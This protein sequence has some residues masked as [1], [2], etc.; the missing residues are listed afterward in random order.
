MA[1]A[2]TDFFQAQDQALGRS[3]RLVVY[4][5]LAVVSMVVA[6]YLA[7]IFA[8]EMSGVHMV[9][10]GWIH[11]DV[12]GGIALGMGILI[13]GGTAVRTLQLR[14]GGTA[15]AELM[16]GRRVDPET[17]DPAER[18]YFNIVEE[19]SIASGTPVPAVYVMDRESGINAFAAGY[20]T[21]DAAVAVTRGALEA[22]NRE[23]LQGVVAH[24]FSHILNGDMRLNIRLVGLLF[25]IFLLTVVGRGILRGATF[26]MGRHRGGGGQ[27]RGGG[28]A[29]QVAIIGI[30]LVVL[31]FLGVFFGRLIQA[32]ISRQ[33]E[34]LAD[35]AAV[36]F[37]RN[38]AGIA[39]AL[40]KIRE[41]S[42]RSE[43][44]DHHAQE[45]GHLFF[46][47]GV[48]GAFSR[49][50]ATHPPLEERIRRLDPGA[51]DGR[52]GSTPKATAKAP[53]R[54]GGAGVGEAGPLSAPDAAVPLSAALVA[55]A[56]RPQAEHVEY[57]RDLMEGM[58]PE[59]RDATR[60]PEGALTVVV[61]LVLSEDP[62]TRKD[63]IKRGETLLGGEVMAASQR[64]HELIRS[65]GPGARLPLLDLALPALQKLP[66][67][68]REVLR[69]AVQPLVQVDGEIRPFDFA[70]FHVLWRSLPGSAE[71]ARR[72]GGRR[73]RSL[74][75][76]RKDVEVLL[77]AVAWAGG[78]K[79]GE[80]R[81][82]FQ[83]GAARLPQVSGGWSLRGDRD[84]DLTRVDEALTRLEGAKA[85]VKR[86]CLEAAAEV[87]RH[88]EPP[89]V[90]EVEM[91]RALAEALDAPM[92]P[93]LPA[94][95]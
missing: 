93:V 65:L 35:A 3:R 17:T 46:A 54:A 41:H 19:M 8:L 81:D 73:N 2:G 76:S 55:S 33:R 90:E 12:F 48:R 86:V 67:E 49:V 60:K 85:E 71:E 28:G 21:H 91:L 14:K 84:L 29:G 45:L 36:Q 78:K 47:D 95:E 87:V 10:Q 4:F 42:S 1:P 31:G 24:E 57:A 56:G 32:A 82:A 68:R 23:E 61:A 40:R 52:R 7:S 88:G 51:G 13:G 27:G 44:R 26:G 25:G 15:V 37:T 75:R 39:G 66:H 69:R 20:S 74:P 70:L 79:E 43:I 83:A 89:R 16:G 77:S 59:L 58:D 94:P 38:P 6:V 9:D 62:E 34:F 72:K 22:L 92:P 64:L 80:A 5:A 30:A 50:L 53:A 11:W 18:R 63:Q